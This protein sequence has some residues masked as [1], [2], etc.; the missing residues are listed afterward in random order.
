VP[1]T[2]A[3]TP[4]ERRERVSPPVP[5]ASAPVA[6]SRPGP[7]PGP[8]RA[9]SPPPPPAPAAPPSAPGSWAE[10]IEHAELGGPA[11]ELARNSSLIAIEGGL[12]RLALRAT[13]E[14]LA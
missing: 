3:T 5:P 1:S 4:P 7:G 10:L 14:H 13:H 6:S 11:G 8:E 2:L 12:V 9:P